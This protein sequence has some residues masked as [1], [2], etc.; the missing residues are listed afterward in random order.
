M[1]LPSTTDVPAKSSNS[2]DGG[3]MKKL[4]EFDGLA[5]S[6]GNVNAEI[7]VGDGSGQSQSC[8]E[9]GV[10]ASTDGSNE[11]EGKENPRKRSSGDTPT[12]GE[13]KAGVLYNAA[14]VG[15]T[16]TNI[17]PSK[18]ITLSGV[19]LR[20]SATSQ[21]NTGVRLEPWTQDER[22]LKREK[23]KQSNRESARRSRLRRQAE[24]GELA[25]KVEALGA[26]NTSLRSEI[27][28]LKENS[29]KLIAENSSLLEKLNNEQGVSLDKLENEEA[30][31]VVVENFLS[32]IDE[33]HESSNGGKL[34][35]LLDSNPR[36]DA[37]AAG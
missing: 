23:R 5:V 25:M 18:G 21:L 11:S 9:N 36:T 34:H 4:K 14:R 19:E 24:T 35:Q 10:E 1:P 3:L 27:S 32:R 31:V 12:S 13:K 2:K 22:A 16:N 33:N 15:E 29:D 26:E 30:P 6:I 20:A 8:G 37:V 28:K 7:T 17:D